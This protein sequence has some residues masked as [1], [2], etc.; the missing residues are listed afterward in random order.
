MYIVHSTLHIIVKCIH[1]YLGTYQFYLPE[2]EI[3]TLTQ[4]KS[5]GSTWSPHDMNFVFSKIP[6][7]FSDS[8]VCRPEPWHTCGQCDGLYILGS[9]SLLKFAIAHSPGALPKVPNR[10]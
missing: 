7:N 9:S 8:L 6:K 1:L 10:V 2:V 3:P 4:R 5:L